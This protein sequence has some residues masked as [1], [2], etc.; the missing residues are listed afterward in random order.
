MPFLVP[1]G[2]FSQITQGWCFLI[3]TVFIL[4]V[5]REVEEGFS[6]PPC[7][8]TSQHFLLIYSTHIY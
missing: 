6:P 3:L 4:N 7:L 8:F 5:F 2:P 1:G